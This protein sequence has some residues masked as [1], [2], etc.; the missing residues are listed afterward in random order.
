VSTEPR[1]VD[2]LREA[3]L[4]FAGYVLYLARLDGAGPVT[5]EV[6]TEKATTAALQDGVSIMTR[7]SAWERTNRSPP[8]GAA[9]L[10]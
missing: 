4:Q 3:A 9:A 10:G 8:P 7:T 5:A 1:L 6:A 2:K